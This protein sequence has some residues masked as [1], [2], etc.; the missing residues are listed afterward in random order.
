M[1]GVPFYIDSKVV[2][3]TF[4]ESGEANEKANKATTSRIIPHYTS[5]ITYL[6]M[7]IGLESPEVA[8]NSR[9]ESVLWD[10][11]AILP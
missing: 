1:R 2:S 6:P 4:F 5:R 9:E 3:G 7:K 11:K 10:V 8:I